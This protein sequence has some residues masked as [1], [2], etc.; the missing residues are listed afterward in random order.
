MSKAV[1]DQVAHVSPIPRGHIAE[2]RPTLLQ[3]RREEVAAEITLLPGRDQMQR[4][5]LE[6]IDP[7]V[8]SVAEDLAPAW[9]LQEMRDAAVLCRDDHAVLE[10]VLD[11]GQDDS[12]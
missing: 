2:R 10:W 4:L 9:F 7:A 6:D 5:R 8:D 11:S 12:G 1:L 3:Q